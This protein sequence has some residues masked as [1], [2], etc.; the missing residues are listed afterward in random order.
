MQKIFGRRTMIKHKNIIMNSSLA[1]TENCRRYQCTWRRLHYTPSWRW[2]DRKVSIYINLFIYL[3]DSSISTLLR[4]T[5]IL[6]SKYVI[7][8]VYKF[9]CACV[10]NDNRHRLNMLN[11][12]DKWKK[13][14]MLCWLLD[15]VRL[16]W[17]WVTS[18]KELEWHWTGGWG[19][20]MKLF[21]RT[22]N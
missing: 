17:P 6:I 20:T 18:V 5:S 19:L 15:L 7:N 12:D 3:E 16:A 13:G 8:Y 14:L 9:G 1:W 10:Y 21:T 2:I 22:L 11:N 4:T